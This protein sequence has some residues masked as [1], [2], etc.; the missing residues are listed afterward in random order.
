MEKRMENGII[1]SFQPNRLFF[2]FLEAIIQS[3]KS[4]SCQIIQFERLNSL[5]YS[6]IRE[7]T[8]FTLFLCF[9][10]YFF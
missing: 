2:K 5:M 3:F 9:A 10:P 1:E 4:F 8:P 6:T 7:I